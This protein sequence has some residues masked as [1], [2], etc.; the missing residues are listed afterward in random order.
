MHTKWK[1]FASAPDQVIAEMW[2]ELVRSAGVDC[3]LENANPSFLGPS[4]YSVRLMAPEEEC[5][6]A[7]RVLSESVDLGPENRVE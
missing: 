4:L 1:A 2:C 5:N 3:R 7:L 6:R